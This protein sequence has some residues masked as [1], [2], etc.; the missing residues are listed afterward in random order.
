MSLRGVLGQTG[1]RPW[2]MPG[3]PWIMTQGW[4]D[5]LFAHWEVEPAAVRALL[6]ASLEPD[7]FAGKAYVG[8]VPFRMAGVRPRFVP[9]L[10]WLSAFPELNLRTYVRPAGGSGK[11]GV[12]FWSLE[13]ANPVAVAVARAWFHLPYMN[14]VMRT[15]ERD[16]WIEYESRRT[17]RGER[18]AVFRGRYRP[19]GTATKTALTCFLTERYCLYASEPS[20]RLHIGEIHHAPWPLEEARAEI[21][22]NTIASAVGLDLVSDPILHFARE[23]KVAIWAPR[24]L[25]G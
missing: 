19:L 13:A 18:P 20:G 10:P 12:F 21:E 24:V 8:V 22:E 3:G 6:P 1:H 25:G 2:P 15:E 7:L 14:A 9:A 4:Y 17:H 5:L 16:G 11:P 23:L